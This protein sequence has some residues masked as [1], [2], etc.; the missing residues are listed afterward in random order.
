LIFLEL[1]FGPEIELPG[2]VKER[3]VDY[4]KES[5]FE[6]RQS[7]AETLGYVRIVFIICL[8]QLGL[9]LG[10]PKSKA[11][12]FSFSSSNESPTVYSE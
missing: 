10:R 11:S 8:D 2:S 5:L 4:E 6:R 3:T 9:Q 12:Y 1:E 7:N